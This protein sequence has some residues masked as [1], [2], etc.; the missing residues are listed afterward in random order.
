MVDVRSSGHPVAVRGRQTVLCPRRP[1]NESDNTPVPG[2]ATPVS[3]E[4]PIKVRPQKSP[5]VRS[6][7]TSSYKFTGGRRFLST[8]TDNQK[9]ILTPLTPGPPDLLPLT[10]SGIV[11]VPT[12]ELRLGGSGYLT[13]QLYRCSVWVSPPPPPEES[14]GD[15]HNQ[16]TCPS[17]RGCRKDAGRR[18]VSGPATGRS[19]RP[20]TV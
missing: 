12:V 18:L 7:S 11:Q 14:L 4:P 8:R 15:L 5:H 1:E 3:Q 10:T 16:S 13:R 9:K 6:L 17:E 2:P 19:D 20:G